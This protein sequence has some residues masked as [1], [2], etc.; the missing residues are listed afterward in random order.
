MQVTLNEIEKVPSPEYLEQEA[1]AKKLLPLLPLSLIVGSFMLNQ[2]IVLMITT[3]DYKSYIG[4][5]Q[6][7]LGNYMVILLLV[8]CNLVYT[9]VAYRIG[10][11]KELFWDSLNF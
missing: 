2:I 10:K 3:P 7:H 6:C 9:T 11:R 1:A 4:V 5:Q 8:L